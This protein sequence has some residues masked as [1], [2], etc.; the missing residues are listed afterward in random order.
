MKNKLLRN[1]FFLRTFTCILICL[2]FSARG[3]EGA[4][5]CA[6]LVYASTHTSRCFSPEFL[7]TVQRETAVT[8][9]RRFKSVKLGS[10]ELFG[11]P[12]VV[13]TGEADFTLTRKERENLRRYLESGGF[14]LASAGCSS[15]EWD[16][17]FRR[18][19]GKVFKHKKST[20]TTGEEIEK[21]AETTDKKEELTKE[22]PVKLE[23]IAMTHPVFSSFYEI[24]K[25]VL[26]HKTA[27]PPALEGL[28]I[29][30]KIVLVYSP[31]GLNDTAHSEG[32]CC[33]GGNEIKNSMQ[34]NVNILIYALLH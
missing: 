2:G 27:Q 8:T 4:I 34:V 25:L 28:V 7:S 33:C 22:T 13:M 19:I 15:K 3:K 20:S 12:F 11:F 9:E 14:I 17:A 1:F 18:E 30:G 32:C 21:A 24:D 23:K 16:T 10:D 26:S 31:H 6:N 29:E 5:Q